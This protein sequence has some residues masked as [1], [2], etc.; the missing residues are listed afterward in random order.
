[1][2]SWTA[3]QPSRGRVG[4]YFI[5]LDLE[6]MLFIFIEITRLHL[7]LAPPIVLAMCLCNLVIV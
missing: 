2:L 3:L 7:D 1:M 4:L 5:V 6:R